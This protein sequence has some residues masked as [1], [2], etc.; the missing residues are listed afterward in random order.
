MV[1]AIT[2]EAD[3]LD[4]PEEVVFEI[5]QNRIDDYRLAAEYINFSGVDLVCVQHEFGIFGGNFGRYVTELLLN[6][7]KPV[8]TTLHTVLQEP[9]PGLRETLLRIADASEYLV[10]LSKKAISILKEVYG[11]PESK[12]A[13]IHHGVPDTAFIDPNFYKDKFKVEGRF[14][15]LTFGLISRNKGIEF[16]LEALPPSSKPTPR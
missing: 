2:N 15:I 12:I 14:V 8:V 13:M 9:A 11:I 6:L 3:S 5:R 16:M 7:Q 1:I 10:V 4:Y